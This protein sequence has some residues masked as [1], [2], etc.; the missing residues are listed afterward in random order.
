MQ[1]ILTSSYG[2]AFTKVDIKLPNTM[3]P[4]TSDFWADIP[5]KEVTRARK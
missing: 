4:H 1:I 3:E 2:I 5:F